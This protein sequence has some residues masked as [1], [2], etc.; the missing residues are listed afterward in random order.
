M[1][2]LLTTEEKN[3]FIHSV[4]AT[5]AYKHRRETQ[6]DKSRINPSANYL[7]VTFKLL[8]SKFLLTMHS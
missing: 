3:E 4:G 7:T 2:P 8:I 5:V 6:G 1:L